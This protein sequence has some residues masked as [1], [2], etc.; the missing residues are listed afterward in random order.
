LVSRATQARTL[1]IFLSLPFSLAPVPRTTALLSCVCFPLGSLRVSCRLGRAGDQNEVTSDVA[2]AR[3]AK[4]LY[5][6][7]AKSSFAWRSHCSGGSLAPLSLSVVDEEI[8]SPDFHIP[9]RNENRSSLINR[10]PVVALFP[11]LAQSKTLKSKKTFHRFVAHIDAVTRITPQGSLVSFNNKVF[12]FTTV[13]HDH[14]PSL[15]TPN[16]R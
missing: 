2:G 7:L 10:C 5:G 16:K 11:F 9:V 8:S 1:E 14:R 4:S 12:F 15:M 13:T 6:V 3:L